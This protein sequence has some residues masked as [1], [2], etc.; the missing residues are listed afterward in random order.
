MQK[1]VIELNKMLCFYEFLHALQKLH[2]PG[3]KKPLNK[4]QRSEN[5]IF[6]EYLLQ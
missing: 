4:A 3:K 6:Q 1:P 2:K 5:I